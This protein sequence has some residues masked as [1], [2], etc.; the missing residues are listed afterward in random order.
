MRALAVQRRMAGNVQG[1]RGVFLPMFAREYLCVVSRWAQDQLR[2]GAATANQ[3]RQLKQLSEAADAL[4]A[5]LAPVR[6]APENVVELDAY[7][8]RRA[9]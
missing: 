6:E 8:R 7:R 9:S 5:D 1:R 4:A 3:R 2:Q